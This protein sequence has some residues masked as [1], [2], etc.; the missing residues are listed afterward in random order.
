VPG[1]DE[2]DDEDDDEEGEGGLASM[3]KWSSL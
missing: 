1:E 2:D 3:R